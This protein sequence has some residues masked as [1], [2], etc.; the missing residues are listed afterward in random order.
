MR[1]SHSSEE[2]PVHDS[3]PPPLLYRRR[4][5][6]KAAG[7]VLLAAPL[8]PLGGCSKAGGSQST[9]AANSPRW[10]SG[11]TAK[12]G[13]PDRFPD[14]F[15]PPG[16]ACV[17][18]CMATI[19]PC[20]ALSPERLDISDGCDG[21]P[22][23]LALRVVDAGCKPLPNAV[24]EIWH[25]NHTGGYSGRI[26]PMCNNDRADLEKRFFRGY[27][28]TSAQGRV[29]FNTCYPG[30]YRG[31]AVHVHLRVMTGDYQ[32]DDRAPAS[33]TTQLL[34]SDAMNRDVFTTHPLYR[35]HGV[36]DTSLDH[37]GVI[38][39][40]PDKSPYLFDTRRMDDGV[41]FASKTLV[42][43]TSPSDSV[44]ETKGQMPPGGGPD[45]PPDA[46]GRP[47]PGFPPPTGTYP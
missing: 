39:A 5:L 24:V 38:G 14:P 29:D 16:S 3:S 32:G 37:D 23:R 21:L 27:Q 1:D 33:V 9:T 19:G 6:L 34:F 13:N 35:T 40:E 8:L 11:G 41:L 25:T 4:R 46:P 42:V 44:C 28:R 22:L 12:I 15:G 20:H 45:G 43:R 47:L 10:A 30:W 2:A 17:L 36:P 31:R 26:A 18:T 7:N